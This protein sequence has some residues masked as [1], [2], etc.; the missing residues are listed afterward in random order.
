[1]NISTATNRLRKEILFSFFNKLGLNECCRCGKP[2][3]DVND[4]TMDHKIPWRNKEDAKSLFFDLNN[5]GFSHL[6]CNSGAI[7]VKAKHPSPSSYKK[8]CRCDECRK[9]NTEAVNKYRNTRKL[10]KYEK[11]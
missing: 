1:M 8:G 7:S 3:T 9:L 2:I 5:I 4:F 11:K 6:K 10:K